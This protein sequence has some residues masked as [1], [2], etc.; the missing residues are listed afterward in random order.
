LYQ[1]AAKQQEAGAVRQTAKA[2]FSIFHF[3]QRRSSIE[4]EK[5]KMLL[6]PTFC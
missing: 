4:N 3:G 2:T 5:W 6:F 1:T